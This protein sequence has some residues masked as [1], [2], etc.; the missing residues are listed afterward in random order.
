MLGVKRTRQSFT[1]GYKLKV[2]VRA[3]VQAMHGHEGLS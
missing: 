2:I 1:F 3:D